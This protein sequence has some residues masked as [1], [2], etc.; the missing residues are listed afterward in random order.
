MPIDDAPFVRKVEDKDPSSLLHVVPALSLPSHPCQHIPSYAPVQRG[1][2]SDEEPHTVSPLD[3]S[4][5]LPAPSTTL[6]VSNLVSVSTTRART[7]V[8]RHPPLFRP[9]PVR[10]SARA[11]TMK[12]ESSEEPS[13]EE[14]DDFL[15]ESDADD[16]E[17]EYVDPGSTRRKTSKKYRRR[18]ASGQTRYRNRLSSSPYPSSARSSS[19]VSYASSSIA[20]SS[21][22]ANSRPGSRN[23]QVSNMPPPRRGEGWTKTGPEAWQCRWCDHVQGNRRAPDMERHILSHFRDQQQ[24]QWVCCG[25][26]ARDADAYGVDT[27]RNPWVFKGELMVGGCHESFSR[28]DALKRH[29]N[30]PNVKCN[31]S[32]MYSRPED[33]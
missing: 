7:Q 5:P 23:R 20:S 32:T 1:Y 26:P 28:M 14:D 17:D 9:V 22:G 6:S 25:V 24:R 30:N 29:W 8:T 2:Y 18:G 16:S 21:I 27:Q 33:E 13:A 4:K 12:R 11:K 3:V 15:L 19:A 10:S 31:G